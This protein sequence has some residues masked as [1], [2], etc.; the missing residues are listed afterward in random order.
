MGEVDSEVLTRLFQHQV[1][2]TMVAQRR[3]SREF[4][5]KLRSWHPSGFG[6]YRSRPIETDNRPALERLAAYILRPSFAASRLRYQAEQGRIEYR[7]A[8][9]VRRTLDALDWIALVTSHIPE[10][11][12]QISRYYGE[13]RM[14][15]LS[16]A[17]RES[18]RGPDPS[19]A[20]PSWT[21][22]ERPAPAS[23]G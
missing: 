8:K 11:G 18:N 13:Y 22:T 1:L 5:Q 4:A 14:E 20:S 23:Q 21:L 10:P 16:E 9:G 19:V 7:T 12:D 6:V 3:L 15:C 17:G 2:E